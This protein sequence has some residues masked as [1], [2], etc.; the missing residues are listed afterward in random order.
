MSYISLVVYIREGKSA[1]LLD[2]LK[3]TADISHWVVVSERL[4]DEGEEDAAILS[5]VIPHVWLIPPLPYLSSRSCF[6]KSANQ[7]TRS[8]T[9]TP[10]QEQRNPLSVPSP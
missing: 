4:L 5:R 8:V 2:R 3:I 9:F 10:A 1:D 6:E 7:T